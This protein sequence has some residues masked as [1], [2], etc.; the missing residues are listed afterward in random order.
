VLIAGT[1]PF[2]SF[3]VEHKVTREARLQVSTP[4]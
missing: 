4:A 1:L 2:A 3:F